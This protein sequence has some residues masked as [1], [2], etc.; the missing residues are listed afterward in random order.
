MRKA[1]AAAAASGEVTLYCTYS[2]DSESN[3]KSSLCQQ[4]ALRLPFQIT[5]RCSITD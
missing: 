5:P 1:T 2:A 4:Q 3:R